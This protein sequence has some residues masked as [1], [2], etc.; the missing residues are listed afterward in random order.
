[1]PVKN[2]ECQLAEMQIGRF[3]SGE[4]LSSE[5]I[6]QLDA[7][8][9]SCK[10]C[11]E[12]LK[13]RRQALKSMLHQGYA[14]VTTDLP[15]ARKEHLLIKALAEKATTDKFTPPRRTPVEAS[16]EAEPRKGWNPASILSQTNDKNG[17]VK[18]TLIYSVALGIVLFAM[19]YLSHGQN[20]LFGGSAEQAFPPQTQA[21]APT[22]SVPQ[23]AESSKPTQS[24][25]P[26]P[27][28]STPPKS[29]PK[30]GQP[31]KTTTPAEA[32]TKPLNTASDATTPDTSTTTA[33]D[34]NS[35]TSKA[36]A[37]LKDDTST[38]ASGP[39]KAPAKRIIH[40]PRKYVAAAHKRHPSI[41]RTP[42][43]RA[44][45][46]H[47]WMKTAKPTWGVRIYGEDGKP[48]GQ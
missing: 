19:G 9:A 29:E 34:V 23:A 32:E 11:S 39:L 20:N 37:S 47:H 10:H 40:Q 27:T 7:H 48:I 14:A 3:V 1:M 41:R 12:V 22:P 17:S 21:P 44:P 2:V 46:H 4:T 43:H 35:A 36:S 5:A 24:S 26:A 25:A 8:L 6:K 30:A 31:A 28:V 33:D 45:N 15:T 42:R 38:D 16:P 13:D 18:K